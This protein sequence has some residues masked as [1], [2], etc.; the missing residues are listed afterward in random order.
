MKYEKCC[1]D[2]NEIFVKESNFNIK[3]RIRG[4]YTVKQTNKDCNCHKTSCCTKSGYHI[5]IEAIFYCF[6]SLYKHNSPGNLWR[7]ISYIYYRNIISL[8][9]YIEWN[10][11]ENIV[12]LVCQHILYVIS[13]VYQNI[14]HGKEVKTTYVWYTNIFCSRYHTFI[15]IYWMERKWKQRAFGM[16]TYSAENII[17]LSKY[18]VGNRYK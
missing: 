8:S 7:I 6:I 4:W 17:S 12:C 11:N 5:I 2:Y 16:P 1:H 18:I 13:Q 3:W 15:K 14:L 10:R 9:K